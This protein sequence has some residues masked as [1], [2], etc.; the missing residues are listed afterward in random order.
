MKGNYINLPDHYNCAFG[1]DADFNAI[2][3]I[4]AQVH[5]LD[6]KVMDAVAANNREEALA[7]I[8]QLQETVINLVGILDKLIEKYTR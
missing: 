1:K 7:G 6:H 8:N 5:T 3:P 2:E 4:H